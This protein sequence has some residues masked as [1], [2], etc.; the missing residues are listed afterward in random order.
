[1]GQV[2]RHGVIAIIKDGHVSFVRGC[3]V[4]RIKLQDIRQHVRLQEVHGDQESAS[5]A[6]AQRCGVQALS[7]ASCYSSSSR[8]RVRGSLLNWKVHQSLHDAIYH[9]I[10]LTVAHCIRHRSP[11]SS[12]LTT[13]YAVVSGVML[14]GHLQHFEEEDLCGI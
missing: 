11:S 6:D 14:K 4:V 3:Q 8:Q 13:V 12:D 2:R 7:A 1:M 5:L 10:Y 9:M